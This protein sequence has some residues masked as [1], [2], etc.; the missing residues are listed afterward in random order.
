[1]GLGFFTVAGLAAVVYAIIHHIV[2]KTSL[3]LTGGLIEH[4]GGSSRLRRLGGMITTAPLLAALFLFSV[5]S[6]VGVPPFSG[7]VAKL[8]L[9]EAGFDVARVRRRRGEPARQPAD[10]ARD[11]PHLDG[12]V[13]EPG[14]GA[15]RS[16]PRRRRRAGSGGPPLMVIPTVA[17]RRV[18]PRDRGGGGPAVRAQSSGPRPTSSTRRATCTR[19]WTDEHLPAAAARRVVAARVGRDHVANIVSGIVVAGL[20]C[21]SRFRPGRERPS[22]QPCAPARRSV[23]SCCTCSVSSWSPTCSSPARS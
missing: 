10:A 18:Q 15:R 5:L 13:L 14:R 8:A 20:R 7:F 22:A 3:F 11:D 16:N 19:C 23:G 6:L 12:R 17:A 4:A 2:V 1:M 21:S 9:T